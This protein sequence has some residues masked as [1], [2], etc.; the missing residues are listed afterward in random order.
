VESVERSISTITAP[1]DRFRELVEALYSG[2][3]RLKFSEDAIQVQLPSGQVIEISALSSGE[4]HLIFILLSALRAFDFSFLVDEPELSMHVDW[5]LRLVQTLQ[6]I[7]PKM[8][9]ILAT[10]SP[11]IMADVPDSQ[12]IR[13]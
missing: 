8:Q 6:T 5:Q 4:K 1:R 7:N 10:H 13:L 2:N 11:E 12:I 3:K 9:S